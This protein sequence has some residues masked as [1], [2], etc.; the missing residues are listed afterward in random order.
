MS[1]ILP[2]ILLL[3]ISYAY[4]SWRGAPWVPSKTADVE[5]FIKLAQISDGKIVY[6]LGCGDGRILQ[7]VV[8]AGSDARGFELSLLPYL[9]AKIR[10]FRNR[11]KCRIE[12]GD[13]WF[14]NLSEADV[15]YIF[16]MPKIY[17]KLV[18]KLKAE[19]KPGTK[20][21]SYVWPLPG[22]EPVIIDK[23]EKHPLLYLYEM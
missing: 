5:R 12:Y 8:L 18:I 1:L 13:F 22:L 17:E 10:L 6:D 21:V 3:L 20:V 23:A 19:L 9:L 2:I 14:K 4:G 16:L 15:V 7:A 11:K